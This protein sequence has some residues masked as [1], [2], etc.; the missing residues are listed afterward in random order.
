[1]GGCHVGVHTR[2]NL[3]AAAWQKVAVDVESLL[4]F[5][6]PMNS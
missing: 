2:A 6:W 3:I 5:E 1:M 4:D